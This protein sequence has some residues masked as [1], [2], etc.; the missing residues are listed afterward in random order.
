MNGRSAPHVGSEALQLAEA[1][2]RTLVEQLPAIVWAA[3]LDG[4]TTY[5]SPQVE[6]ILGTPVEAWIDDPEAWGRQIHPEDRA[7]V[8]ATMAQAQAAGVKYR[9]EYRFLR[10]DGRVVWVLDEAVVVHDGEGRPVGVQGVAL[11]ITERKQA[12]EEAAARTREIETL[13]RISEIVRTGRPLDDIYFEI[14]AEVEAA[15]GFSRAAI[16]LYDEAAGCLVHKGVRGLPRGSD[17][18]DFVAGLDDTFSGIVVRT[19][20]PFVWIEGEPLPGPLPTSAISSGTRAFL[21][22]PMIVGGRVIGALSVGDL[23]AHPIEPRLVPLAAG[24]ANHV[25]TLIERALTREALEASERHFHAAFDTALDAMVVMDDAR[26]YVAAN[27][28]AARL[29]GLPIER[30]LERRFGDFSPV[31]A[32]VD[33]IW[34]AM[35]EGRVTAGEWRLARPDGDLRD[36]EYSVTMN[37]IPGRHLAVVRDVTERKREEAARLVRSAAMAAVASGIVITDAEGRIE[38]VNPEF[39]RMSGYTLDEVRELTPRVLRSGRHDAAYYARLWTT[40]QSGQVWRGNMVNRRKDGTLYFEEQSITP[41]RMS[42]DPAS[43]ITHFVAVKQDV[44]ERRRTEDALRQSEEYHRSLLDNALDLIVVLDGE[45]VVRYASPSVER[46]LGYRPEEMVGTSTLGRLHPDDLARVSQL[47]RT[48]RTTPGFT[49][50][51]EYRIRHKDGT[52]RTF[53]AV[54]SSLLHHPAVAGIIVN[55]RDVTERK[56]SEETQERLRQHLRHSEKLAAMGEL[57]AGVAH[58]L[59]NPLSVVIGH[60]AILTRATDPAVVGRAEKIGRAAERCGRIVKNFLALARQYPPERTS[61]SLNQIVRDALEVL[62]YPL[63]VDNVEVTTELAEDVP[64]LAADGHQ[65]QQVVVNL[66]TNAH[67][68][69]RSRNDTRRLSLRSGVGPDATV[70]LEVSDSGPGMPPEV[71]ARLF[72]P[73]FTTKPVGQGTGLGLSICK[74]IV[75]GHGGRISL[76]GGVGRGATFRLELPIGEPITASPV[77]DQG[78]IGPHR[79]IL[80][81]DDEVEVGSVMSELLRRDG[82]EVDTAVNGLEA[83]ARLRARSYDAVVSDIRMPQLD[84]VGLWTTVKRDDPALASRF[85]FFTGDTLSGATTEFLERTGAPNIRKPFTLRDIR[86]ALARVAVVTTVP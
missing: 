53:E 73:F 68:A 9:C 13:H 76:D 17:G 19:G 74:G 72:E 50:S 2:F 51:V 80:V 39:T 43:P 46:V 4:R 8:L 86:V 45:A 15:I 28:A 22:V 32:D 70:W 56:Q 44:S 62:A 60:T 58:E 59:N 35:I 71:Q 26:A 37:F 66:V 65:L 55:A 10:A 14:T 5:V 1:K 79:R 11:D 16:V 64:L 36:V 7:R 6:R 3:A 77:T 29:F 23:T 85:V 25:A 34:R 47:L 21:G 40:V 83:L 12:A 33:G 41:V 24:I 18:G 48:G 78:P 27:P 81:V 31:G 54:A 82:H 63:R 69:M 38:W 67:Q 49:A 75:E 84:G 61:V 20:Q 57:L 52:Y 30:L 42:E